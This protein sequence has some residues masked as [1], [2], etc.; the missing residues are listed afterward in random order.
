METVIF[1]AALFFLKTIGIQTLPPS[2]LLWSLR[3]FIGSP[4]VSKRS[5]VSR[6][7][8]SDGAAIG[9]ATKKAGIFAM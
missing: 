5:Y 2:F 4:K 3:G 9:F 6:R 1:D 8:V 7:S